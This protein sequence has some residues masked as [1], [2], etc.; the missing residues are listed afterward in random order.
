MKLFKKK[1]F[2]DYFSELQAD[3]VDI[4]LENVEN[5]AREIYIYCSYEDN[6]IVSSYFY[7]IN[8]MVV[9]RGCLNDAIRSGEEPYDVSCERQKQVTEILIEDLKK[10]KDI[11]QKYNKPMPTEIKI[12]YNVETNHMNADYKYENVYSDDSEKIA[13]DV[14]DEWF[15]EVKKKN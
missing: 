9:S 12:V 10:I 4:C 7:N 8:G 2:E 15:E 1:V 14:L 6:V 3:M 5:R 11:C 13:Y